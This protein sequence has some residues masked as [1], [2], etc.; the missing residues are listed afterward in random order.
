MGFL[1]ADSRNILFSNNIIYKTMRNAVVVRVSSD[2]EMID[3]L[4]VYNSAR[5]WNLDVTIRDYQVAVDICVGERTG[6]CTNLLIQ[7]NTVAGGQGIGFTAPAGDC[8][9]EE[10]ILN[11]G[12]A[13]ANNA[14]HSIGAGLIA[15]IN[16]GIEV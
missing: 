3:N 8:S 9:S 14:A 11:S 15:H 4:I 1:A 5:E 16:S 2:V 13:F 10:T 6:V 12:M 7:G